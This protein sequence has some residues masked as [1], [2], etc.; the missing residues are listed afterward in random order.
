M[1]NLTATVV[2]CDQ[3]ITGTV[4]AGDKGDKGLKGDKGDKG[5]QGDKGP[6]VPV[7][8]ELGDDP[9]LAV[10]Q[11]LLTEAV[12]DMLQAN[13]NA[14]SAASE[15]ANAASQSALQASESEGRAAQSA[16][17]AGTD[18]QSAQGAAQDAHGL[19]DHVVDQLG[20]LGALLDILNGEVL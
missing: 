10:S 18:A 11:K 14:V 13:S 3:V 1:R 9:D 16:L 7:A 20:D 4:T 12:D 19:L 2:D 15:Q 5:D 17:S 6:P 8:H